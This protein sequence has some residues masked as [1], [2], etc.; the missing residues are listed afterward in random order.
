ML[1]TTVKAVLEKTFDAGDE[2]YCVYLIREGDVVLYIGR[3]SD[4]ERRL[5]EHFGLS[6]RESGGSIGSFY[7]QHEAEAIAWQIELYTLEDCEPYVLQHLPHAMKSYRNPAREELSDRNAEIAMIRHFRP[8]LN[9]LNNFDPSPLPGKYLTK[10]TS[11]F[12]LW[13]FETPALDD[14]QGRK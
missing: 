8:C 13:S 5:R 2:P 6:W 10:T 7:E 9:V 1:R 11:P 3:S 14:R 4:P 12:P